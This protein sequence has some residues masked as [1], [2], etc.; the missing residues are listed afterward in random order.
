MSAGWDENVS[1]AMQLQDWQEEDESFEGGGELVHDLPPRCPPDPADL[2]Q[3]FGTLREVSPLAPRDRET[4][5]TPGFDWLE[6]VVDKRRAR[7]GR[8]LGCVPED[9]EVNACITPLSSAAGSSRSSCRPSPLTTGSSHGTSSSSSSSHSERGET[10]PVGNLTSSPPWVNT[11]GSNPALWTNEWTPPVGHAVCTQPSGM[12]YLTASSWTCPSSSS[13][14]SSLTTPGTNKKDC[15]AEISDEGIMQRWGKTRPGRDRWHNLDGTIKKNKLL[16]V[17]E[18]DPD[19]ET[20]PFELLDVHRAA[21]KTTVKAVSFYGEPFGVQVDPDTPPFFGNETSTTAGEGEDERDDAASSSNASSQPLLKREARMAAYFKGQWKPRWLLDYIDEKLKRDQAAA[22][23][24]PAQEVT[25][26]PAEEVEELPSGASNPWASLGWWTQEEWRQWWNMN[27]IM[28]DTDHSSSSS[29][30]CSSTSTSTTPWMTAMSLSPSSWWATSVAE[31]TLS[32][33]WWGEF[34]WTAGMT[35]VVLLST[36]SS[37]SSSPV[38][39]NHGLFPVV[40]PAQPVTDMRMELTNAETAVL[41]EA[42]V[43]PQSLARLQSMMEMLD[44]H[45]AE[46]RGPE[47]RWAL[48]CMVRRLDEGTQA[49]DAIRG[50]L[51]RRLVPRGYLPVRRYPV[52]ESERW[53]I[54]NWARNYRDDFVFVLDRHL[55]T[56]MI[57]EDQNFPREFNEPRSSRARSSPSVVASEAQA[58]SPREAVSITDDAASERSEHASLSG[59]TEGQASGNSVNSD[60]AL[61]ENGV[62]MQFAPAPPGVTPCGPPPP[63]PVNASQTTESLERV[64]EGETPLARAL[65]GELLGVWREPLAEQNVS[66]ALDGSSSALPGPSQMTLDLAAAEEDNEYVGTLAT[67]SSSTT[68]AMVWWVC[69]ATQAESDGAAHEPV[70]ESDDS[71]EAVQMIL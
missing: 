27:G 32:S 31:T 19:P 13:D 15:D 16:P 9:N 23:E 26:Q 40:G 10:P 52:G 25:I 54:F 36:T 8:R 4:P 49:L 53:S 45:Q 37:T 69:T 42:A 71:A 61:D 60:W 21:E 12:S 64:A 7:G 33:S 34:S 44:R 41:Q 3:P 58:S 18:E 39:P 11:S 24:S 5:V 1:L 68:T 65:R 57:P 17:P 20:A 38:L 29:W 62:L 55:Q 47:A 46:G 50:V 14:A 2:P 22:S 30:S 48:G 59:S 70:P 66:T 35:D 63:E 6:A 51:S 28:D 43:P 67:S 56:G